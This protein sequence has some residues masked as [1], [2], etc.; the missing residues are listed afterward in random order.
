MV[1]PLYINQLSENTKN[2]IKKACYVV[3]QHTIAQKTNEIYLTK[4]IVSKKFLQA[5]K[6]E[7]NIIRSMS[8]FKKFI[9]GGCFY[10]YDILDVILQESGDADKNKYHWPFEEVQRPWVRKP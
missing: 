8:Q 4:I 9:T 7:P 3:R 6:I 10:A 2:W 1:T 5:L